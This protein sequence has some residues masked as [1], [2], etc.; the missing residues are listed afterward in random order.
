[1]PGMSRCWA[2][3]LLLCST[4]CAAQLT[5]RF[6]LEKQTYAVGEP[7]FLYFELSNQGAEKQQI[8]HFDPYLFCAG[9]QITVSTEA[10]PNPRCGVWGFAGDCMGSW[11]VLAP[12]KS[13]VERILLNYDHD[14]RRAGAYDV[15]ASRRVMYGD[16][17]AGSMPE[18]LEVSSELH[19]RIADDLQPDPQALRRLVAQLHAK[20]E[21][22]RR[23]AA[24]T[25][26]ALAPPSQE[27]TLLGFAGNA[28]FRQFAPLAFHN[29]NTE[30]SLAAL[31]E[32]VARGH[33]GSYEHLTAAEY[34]AKSGDPRWFPLLAEVARRHARI[35]NYV[36]D[37]A[38]SGGNQALPLLLELMRSSDK[39]FTVINA[40]SA[41]GYTGSRAAVP[42]LLDLLRNP[43]TGLAQ[44]A[45]YSLGQLTHRMA[46][47]PE[48]WPE[49]PQQQYA[50]WAQWWAGAQ[51]TAPIYKAGQ[52]SEFTPLP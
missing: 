38:E 51:N 1:M 4:L 41:L 11:L 5:G 50:R 31:G 10:P 2:L 24:R 16:A 26:A 44:R 34:L 21:A 42:I 52:C 25:L 18:T 14:L 45:A 32:I 43:D 20:D 40:V 15:Q 47:T 39:E 19:F 36:A 6:Y 30:R 12:G 22:A 9:Y 7:V 3:A 28:E 29:L 13:L 37:A 48:F 46:P 27:D 49:H 33:P 17:S 35:G 8:T 23:E